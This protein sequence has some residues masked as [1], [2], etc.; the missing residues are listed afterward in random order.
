VI[1]F[2]V[3]ALIT[4]VFG[5]INTQYI[6]VLERTREIGL[7][8]ALGMRGRH[9]SRL[10]QFEAAW[11]GFLGGTL[12]ALVAVGAGLGL[13]PWITRQ[14]T[15]G[16]GN[17]LL[18]FQPIPIVLLIIALMAIAMLAGYFPARKAAKLDPIEALRTE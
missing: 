8:K 11:I 1:G 13:N 18:I 6:S 2:G 14:L 9:V 4:S 10:F 7:M 3:L 5:I 12:G 16:D 17:Y 15:L